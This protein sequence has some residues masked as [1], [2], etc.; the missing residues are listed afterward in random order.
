MDAW[1]RIFFRLRILARKN[2]LGK[3]KR[4]E[5]HVRVDSSLVSFGTGHSSDYCWVRAQHP[6]A[7]GEFTVL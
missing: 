1:D 3:K 4:R 6:L 2:V 5:G 7:C